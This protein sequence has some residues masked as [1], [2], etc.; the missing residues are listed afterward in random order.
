MHDMARLAVQFM[1][2]IEDVDIQATLAKDVVAKFRSHKQFVYNDVAKAAQR[3]DSRAVASVRKGQSSPDTTQAILWQNS[4]DWNFDR[5]SGEAGNAYVQ[6]S[7]RTA[8]EA[9]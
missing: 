7:T 9:E 3:A 2:S 1:R 6:W 5:V 8:A 4:S